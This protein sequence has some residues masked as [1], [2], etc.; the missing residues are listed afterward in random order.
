MFNKSVSSIVKSFTKVIDD[1]NALALKK[2]YK[3]QKI[4]ED[5]NCLMACH[6][7]ARVE[8]IKAEKIIKKISALLDE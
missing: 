1:L 2:E 4:D 7:E 6:N 3:M 5:I 8:K